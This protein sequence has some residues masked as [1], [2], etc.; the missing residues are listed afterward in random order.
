[1]EISLACKRPYDPEKGSVW[2]EDLT[3]DKMGKCM[4]IVE[5]AL[6]AALDQKNRAAEKT[7][8]LRETL[9]RELNLEPN[10]AKA[11]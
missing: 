3:C 1:M 7:A 9:V 2:C 6:L 8:K 4:A 10:L 11:I 5:D